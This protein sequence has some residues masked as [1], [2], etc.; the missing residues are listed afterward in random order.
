MEFIENAGNSM[1]P[2]WGQRLLGAGA[3]NGD[4]CRLGLSIESFDSRGPLRWSAAN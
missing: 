1:Q 3:D 4:H 2:R